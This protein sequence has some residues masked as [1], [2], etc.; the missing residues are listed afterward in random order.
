M[1]EQARLKPRNFEVISNRRKL[2]QSDETINNSIDA[3]TRSM[4]KAMQGKSIF[5]PNINES[6]FSTEVDIDNSTQKQSKTN[7]KARESHKRL[8][9]R[10]V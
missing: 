9:N 5:G 3:R 7:L 10:S 6:T 8:K 1:R 2:H 4:I